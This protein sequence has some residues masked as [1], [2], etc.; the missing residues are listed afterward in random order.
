[1]GASSRKVGALKDALCL[2]RKSIVLEP[3]FIDPHANIGIALKA[4]DDISRALNMLRR[5]MII[6]PYASRSY[7]GLAD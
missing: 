4:I 2:Y 7:S 3:G 5:S 6:N 1:M